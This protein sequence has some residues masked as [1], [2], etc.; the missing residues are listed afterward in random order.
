[1]D[2]GHKDKYHLRGDMINVCTEYSGALYP[3]REWPLSGELARKGGCE[4]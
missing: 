4:M 1:M 2:G 3:V